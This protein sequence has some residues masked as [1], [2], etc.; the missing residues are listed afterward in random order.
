MASRAEK[1]SDNANQK[2]HEG[3]E[4]NMHDMIKH[5]V[6]INYKGGNQAELIEFIAKYVTTV[7]LSA[8]DNC[9]RESVV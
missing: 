5:E 9:Q 6:D 7:V 4:F 1:F 3:M 8:V 2:F